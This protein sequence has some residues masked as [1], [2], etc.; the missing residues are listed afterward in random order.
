MVSDS[1]WL[2]GAF[3]SSSIFCMS[4]KGDVISGSGIMMAVT[5]AQA[6][7]EQQKQWRGEGCCVFKWSWILL[8]N[9]WLFQI[10]KREPLLLS[11]RLTILLSFSLLLRLS[12]VDFSVPWSKQLASSWS[13]GMYELCSLA[14]SAR[15]IGK[16]V[17]GVKLP[18]PTAT[19]GTSKLLPASRL[20]Y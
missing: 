14:A 10:C 18:P 12:S 2:I 9:L 6:A 20:K 7:L 19:H 13:Q 5:N 3:F 15:Y 4:C 11:L 1:C 8:Q 17:D 16:K